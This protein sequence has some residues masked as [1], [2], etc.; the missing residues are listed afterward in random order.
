MKPLFRSPT[1]WAS[2]GPVPGSEFHNNRGDHL[3]GGIDLNA[4]FGTPIIAPRRGFVAFVGTST[5]LGGNKVE[6]DHGCLSD[7]RHHVTKHYHFG[8]KNTPPSDSIIVVVGQRVG[9]GDTL[10]YCGDSG[11]ATAPHDHYEHWVDGR[12]LDPL[13]F[14]VEYQVVRRPRLQLRFALAYQGAEGPD[15]PYLQERLNHAGFGPLAADG[16]YGPITGQAVRSF[17]VSQGLTVDGIVG[18]NTWRALLR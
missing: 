10:G 9:M 11:N 5:G 3:H 4:P 8:H 16:I 15:I 14:L 6:V 18:R 17:Q 7:G 13:Q 2:L 12:P 1:G